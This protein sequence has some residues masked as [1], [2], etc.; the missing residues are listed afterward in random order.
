VPASDDAADGAAPRR[1]VWT[2]RNDRLTAVPIE[3]GVT[4][5]SNIEVRSGELAEGDVIVTDALDK[6]ERAEAKAKTKGGL[7]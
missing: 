2:W 1:T 4:E 7:F 5:G 3:V 6:N